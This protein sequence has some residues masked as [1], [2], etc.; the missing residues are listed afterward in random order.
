M[1]ENLGGMEAGGGGR[2]ADMFFVL[3]CL[4]VFVLLASVVALL[5]ARTVLVMIVGKSF[6]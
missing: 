1:G 5:M 2:S 3:R 4:F 6:G